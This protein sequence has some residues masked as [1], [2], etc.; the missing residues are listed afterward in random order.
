MLFVMDVGNTQTTVALFKGKEAVHCWRLSTARQRTP[1]E[2]GALLQSLFHLH[3]LDINSV[4]AVAVSSVVPTADWPLRQMCSRY[5]KR[6]PLFVA[7]GIKTGIQI[8]YDN[9]L[10]VGADRIVNA[11]AAGVKYEVPAIV[12]DFGTATTF[13][14]LDDSGNYLGGVIAPGV[15]ISAEA[16]FSHAAKLPKVEISR[17]KR[18][19]GKSTVGSMQSGLYWGYVSL[20]EGI[21]KRMKREY[22]AVKT[23]V[24]TGGLAPLLAKD[25]PNVDAVDENLTLEGLRIIF[26]R[27]AG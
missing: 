4:E 3:D 15:A 5:F 19:I 1:D 7:P 12:V 20:V 10:E 6:E 14:M 25:C 27:N 18:I 13:D 22:G 8:L 17:P 26:E 2:W 21:L 24:A 11:V 23:V 16:L 9:P